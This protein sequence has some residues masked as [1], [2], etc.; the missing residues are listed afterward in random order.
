[1]VYELPVSFIEDL[2]KTVNRFIRKWL[3]ICRNVTDVALYSKHSP[4]PLPF[5]SLVHLFKATKL[6]SHI[7]LLESAHAEVA[8]NVAPSGTG[9]KWR[10][11][12]REKKRFGIS[13]DVGVL[14]RCEL[15]LE[16]SELV[17]RVRQGRM[18]VDFAG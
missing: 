16:N 5:Q 9:R 18:G 10:L 7:Q 17:G 12:E 1:M 14:R 11:C 4:C 15:M 3:G 13:L 8:N 6:N 2:E